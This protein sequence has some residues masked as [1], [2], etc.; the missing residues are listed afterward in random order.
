M[1]K[2]STKILNVLRSLMQRVN[3]VSSLFT[4]RKTV[5]GT[6][7][8]SAVQS[9]PRSHPSNLY[10]HCSEC[11]LEVFIDA[12]VNNN[13]FR[14]IKHGNSTKEEIAIAWRNLFYE[15]CDLSGI[16]S[17]R[18]LF[19]INKEIGQLSSRRLTV[20][21]CIDVLNIL[22]EPAC[23]K[24]LREIGY[25]Y[26]FDPQNPEEYKK[27]IQMVIQKSK[28]IE[29]AIQEKEF[30]YEKILSAFGGKPVT[31][32]DFTKALVEL[33][34]YMKFRINP[35]EITVSE[36][37]AIRQKYDREAEHLARMNSKLKKNA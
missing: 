22:H 24:L 6:S 33:S 29:I 37:L 36:Y 5:R 14:L 10:T 35:R 12:L 26:K 20:K 7:S 23:I 19:L 8:K 13:H 21:C 9:L 17:Y 2:E 3:K 1:K 16:E 31:E 30:Q 25:T 27:D 4:A 11:P 28:S 34:A 15:Y 32:E 18:K